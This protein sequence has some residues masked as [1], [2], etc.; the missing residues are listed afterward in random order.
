MIGDVTNWNTGNRDLTVNVRFTSG[1]G[2]LANARVGDGDNR[3]IYYTYS[4]TNT[5]LSYTYTSAGLITNPTPN[6]YQE[7]NSLVGATPGS[8]VFTEVLVTP[9]T[10]SARAAELRQ[11]VHLPPHA[12]ADDAVGREP[13]VQNHRQS[14]PRGLQHHQRAL[15]QW[16]WLPGRRRL[17]GHAQGV[18]L[19]RALWHH[20]QWVHAAARRPVQGRQVLREEGPRGGRQYRGPAGL[21]PGAVL[22]PAQ[23]RHPHHRRLLEHQRRGHRHR[24]GQLRPRPARQHRRR[25]AGRR[26]HAAADEGQRRHHGGDAH[27]R[28]SAAHHH[29]AIHDEHDPAGAT[30]P[31]PSVADGHHDAADPHDDLAA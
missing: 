12:D 16:R 7:C 9:A 6:F 10:P 1:T 25:T 17:R 23:L 18:L 8:G 13:C 30:G 11:L 15:G 3:P 5:P 31:V 19:Q 4:G 28:A 24:P 20:T 29:A 14:L 2:T 22:V 27:E 21:R 26:H